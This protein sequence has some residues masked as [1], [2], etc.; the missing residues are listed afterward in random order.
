VLVAVVVVVLLVALA[1][2]DSIVKAAIERVGS[3]VTKTTV[4]V[5]D[6]SISLRSG[7]GVVRGLTIGHPEGFEERVM[8]I[9]EAR[10]V[11]DIGSLTSDTII[12]K[13]IIVTAPQVTVEVNRGGTNVSRLQDTLSQGSGDGAASTGDDNPE[14]KKKLI[15]ERITIADGRVDLKAAGLERGVGADLPSITLN[16]IG[17]DGG[18]AKPAEVAKVI[19]AA[20]SAAASQAAIRSGVLQKLEGEVGDKAKSLLE[21]STGGLRGILKR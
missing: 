13:E 15:I 8:R 19:L 7:E 4:S 1:S 11:L 16:D 2:V 17:K 14:N 10:I 12:I 18:G 3:D 6:V 20:V 9:G 21:K 5:D